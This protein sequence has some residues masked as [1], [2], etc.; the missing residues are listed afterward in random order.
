MSTFERA[1]GALRAGRWA[2]LAAWLALAGGLAWPALHFVGA[3]SQEFD[4]PPAT[5]SHAANA[6]FARL[7]PNMS[8]LG[9]VSVLVRTKDDETDVRN[10]F[11]EQLTFALSS[12]I[13]PSSRPREGRVG[14]VVGWATLVQAYPSLQDVIESVL[15]RS[16]GR[17]TLILVPYQQWEGYTEWGT[18]LRAETERWHAEQS[19][20]DE[21]AR[22]HWVE[23][24]GLSTVFQ[25]SVDG[26]TRDLRKMDQFA[27]PLALVVLVVVLQSAPLMIIPVVCVAVCVTAS[28]GV[29]YFVAQYGMK[30]IG[31]CPAVMMSV[32]IAMSFDYSLFLLSRYREELRDYRRTKRSASLQATDA[33]PSAPQRRPRAVPTADNVVLVMQMLRHAGRIV[34][35]SGTV[36]LACFVSMAFLPA[37]FVQTFGISTAVSLFFTIAVN[38]TLTPVLL[39]V[40]GPLFSLE[41]FIPGIDFSALFRRALGRPLSSTT[42]ADG[43]DD[44]KDK[45]AGCCAPAGRTLARMPWNVLAVVAVVCVAAAVGVW[46]KDLSISK[47]SSY[48]LPHDAPSMT[49]LEHLLSTSFPPGIS[50]PFKVLVVAKPG[51]P[52]DPLTNTTFWTDAFWSATSS[53]LANLSTQV[54][55]LTPEVTAAITYLNGEAMSRDLVYG[56]VFQDLI[57]EFA[58][59]ARALYGSV[60]SSDGRATFGIAMTTFFPCANITGFV[61]AARRVLDRCTAEQDYAYYLVGQN[62][63]IQDAVDRVMGTFPTLVAVTTSIIAVFLVVAYRTPA[64]PLRT[65]LTIAVTMSVAFGGAV[66][67]FQK[68]WLDGVSDVFGSFHELYWFTPVGTFVILVGLSLDYDIF[69]YGRIYENR[70]MGDDTKT[71]IENAMGKVTPVIVSA[72]LIM[73]IAFGALM[74]SSV[75]TVVQMGFMLM[76]AVLF[77][78]FVVCTLF[79]PPVV[80]LLGPVNWWPHRPAQST[81]TERERLLP[82]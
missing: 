43:G 16:N 7:F 32:I 68:G 72:G 42:T 48:M 61:R 80:S 49:V 82:Q 71:A 63:V 45:S 9:V 3:T 8:S 20:E 75:M 6:E 74:L 19:R 58:P 70:A 31:F 50:D 35:T 17:A 69:L 29:M 81:A 2:V 21:L 27:L 15:V 10:N 53:C 46:V 25:D 51:A 79:V 44:G 24:V 67:V 38:L 66:L 56:L 36:L 60:V 34:F 73:S 62:A 77:D 40:L 55:G 28:F 5:P 64:L 14:E 33:D 11:T 52:V 18:R 54:G 78:T 30:V 59:L 26:T 13:V 47:D 76:F 22:R 39:I 41:G 57:P 23:V 65:L 37:S 4:A 1:F 12:E